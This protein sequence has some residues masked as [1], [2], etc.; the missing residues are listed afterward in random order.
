MPF[1]AISSSRARRSTPE[2][3]ARVVIERRLGS[4]LEPV[5]GQVFFAPEAHAAYV[6]LG[7][8]DSIHDADGVALPDGPAY[9]SSRG[10]VMGQVSGEVIASAFAVFNPAVVVPCVAHGWSLTDAPSVCDARNRGATGQLDR[11]LGENPDGKDRVEEL[12]GKATDELR[13]EG[14]PLAAGIS[15]LDDPDHPWG[16]IFR[17][18][19]LVREFRGD[20]HTAAWIG[21]GFDAVQI[22]LL[23]E[24]YW[25]LP[26]R[27]YTRT[28][29][30]SEADFDEAQGRLQADG[31]LDG[32]GFT[33]R[34][35][36]VREGIE[37]HTDTMMRQVMTALGDDAEELIELLTPWGASIRAAKGY[38]SSGPHD[39]AG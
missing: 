23:T 19:D 8:D 1:P 24:L 28:R 37:A 25:G 13:V 29:G 17:L 3:Y 21:A 14:R 4:A 26:L 18:G 11:I 38:L 34:G 5:I 31:L 39:L 36:T 33:E 7:F 10:S 32:D 22:G 27:S 6:E 12:L 15:G 9:F 2:L 20:C 16:R 35:R 30:W